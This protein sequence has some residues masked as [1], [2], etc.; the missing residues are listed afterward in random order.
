VRQGAEEAE[1]DLLREVFNVRSGAGEARE[2]AE[3]RRLVRED[4]EG[5]FVGCGR[6]WQGI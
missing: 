5:E 2:G 4:E 6:E 3:D 1:E